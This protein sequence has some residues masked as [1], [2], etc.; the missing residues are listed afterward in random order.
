MSKSWTSKLGW[1]D[2]NYILNCLDAKFGP[3]SKGSPM[4]TFEFEVQSPASVALMI[5]GVATDVTVAGAKLRHWSVTQSIV[6]GV[7]DAEKTVKSAERIEAVCKAFG[8][9]YATFN[10]E[11]PDLSGFIGKKVW[12]FVDSKLVEQ[13]R[14]PT[15]EQIANK[16]PGDI[17]TNPI[18][19]EK[20]Q[21]Y[22]PKVKEFIGLAQV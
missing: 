9:D 21:N 6:N 5:D 20:M 22:F 2:D 10:P 19:G 16:Q 12:A 7:V 17:A 14:S 3:S 8:V 13:R 18:T 4:I 1:F 11:N 15:P